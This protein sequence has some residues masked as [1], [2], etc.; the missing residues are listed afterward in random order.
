MKIACAFA[1]LSLLAGM[2]CGDSGTKT[3]LKV[4]RDTRFTSMYMRDADGVTGADGTISIA[5]DDGSSL[6]M[7]GDCFLGAVTG[8]KR[9]NAERMI[10]NA[11]VH[12]S[13]DGQNLGSY[14]GG[15]SAAPKSLLIPREVATAG[16]AYW[17][18]P[19]HGFQEGDTLHLFMT[20]FYQGGDG[21]WG[22]V[23]GGTDY[24]RMN[25]HDYSV[26]SV[27]EIYD[28]NCPI[29]WGHCVMEN[30]GYYY[31]YG[32]RADTGHNP[33]ELCVSRA[34]MDSITGKLGAFEYFDGKGWSSDRNAAL[35][36]RGI[37]VPVSEQFSVFHY[38]ELFILLTQRR[39]AQTG[40][41]YSYVSNTPVGPWRNKKQLYITEE[42]NRNK[43][44]FTYNAMAH[45]QFI[46]RQDEL[47]ICYNVNSFNL[48]DVYQD[49]STYRPVFLRVPM[50]LIVK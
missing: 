37:D 13:A 14:F 10:N 15:T 20:K 11:F 40:D 8:G 38:K 36:C 23:F 47:L 30:D 49:V 39:G 21:Q 35:A 41:I 50:R 1:I 44:L 6:F 32:S 29:H 2:S 17:Y 46:N 5:L 3:P 18:W 27:D 45:P 16:V 34:R 24:I 9:N 43:N 12:V 42:Q 31:V 25:L 22:F 7:T 48:P 28:K 26:V 33:A 19:G 4:S